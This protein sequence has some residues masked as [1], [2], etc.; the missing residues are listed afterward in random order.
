[1]KQKLLGTALASLLLAAP[2]AQSAEFICHD[3]VKPASYSPE[4]QRL[5]D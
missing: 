5:V 1:M 2:L 3:D 4:E